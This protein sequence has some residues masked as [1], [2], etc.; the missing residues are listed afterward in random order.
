M[1][2]RSDFFPQQQFHLLMV[3]GELHNEVVVQLRCVT[4][5]PS[6]APKTVRSLQF[7]ISGGDECMSPVNH[8]GSLF[9]GLVLILG[10][11]AG[12]GSRFSSVRA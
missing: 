9:S 5:R 6:I 4:V 1:L 3:F 2:P 12:R 7:K 10:M 11:P 8:Q